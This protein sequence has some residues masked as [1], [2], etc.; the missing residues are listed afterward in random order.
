MCHFKF[1]TLESFIKFFLS[2]LNFI[3]VYLVLIRFV[4]AVIHCLQCG[5]SLFSA[6]TLRSHLL[7]C[8]REP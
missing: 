3:L 4:F 1:N 7:C 2:R 8:P 6:V 5:S